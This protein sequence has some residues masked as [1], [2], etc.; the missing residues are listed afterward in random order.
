M[1]TRADIDRA[2]PQRRN[3]EGVA[4]Q[5]VLSIV[6]GVITSVTTVIIINELAKKN[7]LTPTAA[8]P[9]TTPA[10]GATKV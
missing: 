7:V 5:F 3:P 9:T 2:R 6:A 10:A 8:A 4:L 1:L